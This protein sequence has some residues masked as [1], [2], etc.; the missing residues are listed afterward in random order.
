MSN[1]E[2]SPLLR[3]I[4]GILE[5][6]DRQNEIIKIQSD[7][8]DGLFTMLLQHVSTEDEGLTDILK[9]MET[10]VELRAETP[11]AFPVKGGRDEFF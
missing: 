1:G 3:R 11:G 6:V 7:V 2:P 9:D 4:N 8:I 10:A 5:A